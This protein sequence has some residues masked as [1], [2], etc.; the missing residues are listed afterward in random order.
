MRFRSESCGSK[1][2]PTVTTGSVPQETLDREKE[3]LAER[4][5]A[6]DTEEEI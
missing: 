2:R 6:Y 3:M 4:T 1:S 5:L